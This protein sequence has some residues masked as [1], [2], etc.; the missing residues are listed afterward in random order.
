MSHTAYFYTVSNFGNF[1][2]LDEKPVFSFNLEIG[3]VP[4]LAFIVQ[5]Y[6]AHR[7]FAIDNRSWPLAVAIQTFAV[8][9]F[10]LGIGE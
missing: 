1:A 7:A 8:A 3:I 10:I 4:I 6:F 9:Q 5:T 2:A